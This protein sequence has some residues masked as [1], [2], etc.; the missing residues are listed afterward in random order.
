MGAGAAV[1]FHTSLCAVEAEDGVVSAL[2][3]SSKAG[4]SAYK[5]KVYVDCTGDGDLAAWASAEF[6]KG[7]SGSG[8]MQPATHCFILSNVDTYAYQ[9]G[10]RP[11]GNRSPGEP[12]KAILDSGK[13][14]EIKDAHLCNSLIGPG[15]SATRSSARPAH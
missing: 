4:L 11:R 7:D 12:I 13:Y 6:E 3:L 2:I 14:P 8:D 1:L 10:H 5:A 15:R 9:H